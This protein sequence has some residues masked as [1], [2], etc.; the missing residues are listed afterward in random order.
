M[1]FSAI[2]AMYGPAMQSGRTATACVVGA[3]LLLI[4][5]LLLWFDNSTVSV[6]APDLGDRRSAGEVG[7]SIAPWDAGLN[8]NRDGPGGEHSHPFSDEVAADCYA[9]NMTRFHAALATGVL[10][11]LMLCMSALAAFRS[12]RR[13]LTR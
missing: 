9:A 8:G 12:T 10:A 6:S 13:V 5:A 11:L 4:G 1:R 3:C 7:C 2:V